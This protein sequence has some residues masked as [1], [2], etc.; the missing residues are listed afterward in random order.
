MLRTRVVA[1]T[2]A[3]I[4]VLVAVA[5]SRPPEQQLLTQFFRAA[6]AR[7]NSTTARMSA[8]ELNPREQGSVESFSI[9]SIS[10]E[11]R[12][13]LAFKSLMAAEEKAR[14]DEAEFLKTKME[15]QNANI[16]AIEEVLKLERDPAA[17]LTPAQAKV[18]GEWDKWREEINA[19]QREVSAARAAFVAATGLAESSLTQPGQPPLDPKAFE[20]ESIVKDVVVAAKMKTADGAAVDKTLTITFARV[21]GSQGGVKRDGR[22]MITK[23]AGL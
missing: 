18:K 13:P 19:H 6:R 9:T 1:S 16:K 14:A 22:P 23:I 4:V 7:D 8:A 5:C 20:G 10:D 3:L 12:E 15:Y 17:K 2:V 21:S 11:R